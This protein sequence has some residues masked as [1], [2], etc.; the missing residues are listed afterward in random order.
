MK[1]L[2]C[3]SVTLRLRTVIA[4]SLLKSAQTGSI[5]A[6]GGLQALAEAGDP[7]ADFD[8]MAAASYAR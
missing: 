8:P 1:A 4:R 3:P 2:L 7:D 6:F 5:R